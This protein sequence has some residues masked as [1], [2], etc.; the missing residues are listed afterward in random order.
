MGSHIPNSTGI[1]DIDSLLFPKNE[2]EKNWNVIPEL[3][4]G[5]YF[6]GSWDLESPFPD[7]RKID[8][9]HYATACGELVGLADL[10][11]NPLIYYYCLE[12]LG[13]IFTHTIILPILQKLYGQNIDYKSL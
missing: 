6:F 4:S 13:P 7:G 2:I 8:P 11:T 5:N 10:S 9:A 3:K 1:D 12:T